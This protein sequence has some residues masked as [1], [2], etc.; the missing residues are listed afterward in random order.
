MASVCE[1]LGAN[2][3]GPRGNT[4]FGTL[5][6]QIDGILAN[7]AD[8]GW[9]ITDQGLHIG[10]IAPANGV[11]SLK[12]FDRFVGALVEER[13]CDTLAKA[14]TN[15][16]KID[17]EEIVEK[18]DAEGFVL[19]ENLQPAAR[20]KLAEYNRQNNRYPV[21][22]FAGAIKKPRLI[23]LIRLRLALARTRYREAAQTNITSPVEAIPRCFWSLSIF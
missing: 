7:Y 2:F 9:W 19:K 23:R 3:I 17:L 6:D 11:A 1:E 5:G 14:N 20:D 16:S 4:F 12:K 15:L 13:W 10:A 22:T 8:L 21:R 18:V